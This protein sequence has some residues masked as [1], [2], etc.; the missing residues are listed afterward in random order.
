MHVQQVTILVLLDY[1]LQL[2]LSDVIYE[3]FE[4]HNPCFIRLCFAIL[5]DQEKKTL[6]KVTIL[7]L[8]DY[9]LQSFFLENNSVFVLS[10]SLFY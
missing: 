10:Q 3:N 8:L 1:V 6:I 7:V 5:E 9:V 4:C 2:M